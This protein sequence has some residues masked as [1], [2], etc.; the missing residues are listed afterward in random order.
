VL[1]LSL[2]EVWAEINP[3]RAAVRPRS[4]QAL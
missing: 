3:P 4:L 1:S 2:D